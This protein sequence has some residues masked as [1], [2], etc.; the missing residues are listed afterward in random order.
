[1]DT[2]MKNGKNKS[3]KNF[4]G[5]QKVIIGC[6]LSCLI[7]VV[8]FG[9]SFIFPSFASITSTPSMLPTLDVRPR[10]SGCLPW[11]QLVPSD[12]NK[13]MCV[14]GKSYG[15]IGERINTGRGFVVRFD[16]YD[17]ALPTRF[18]VVVKMKFRVGEQSWGPGNRTVFEGRFRSL[19]NYLSCVGVSGTVVNERFFNDDPKDTYQI[20]IN[21][22]ESVKE[23]ENCP[24]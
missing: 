23:L 19:N 7:L 2:L 1:M 22:P 11:K 9:V 24:D 6:L 21:F 15:A 10:I 18:Y 17:S 8:G 20:W 3:V 16:E 5:V 13:E 14:A 4:S 12:A